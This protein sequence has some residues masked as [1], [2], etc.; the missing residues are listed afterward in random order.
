MNET[1]YQLLPE[2][3]RFERRAQSRAEFSSADVIHILRQRADKA[4]RGSG[5]YA[6][7]LGIPRKDP[8]IEIRR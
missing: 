4:V 6:R 8:I 1:N 2:I 5:E 7:R 3:V